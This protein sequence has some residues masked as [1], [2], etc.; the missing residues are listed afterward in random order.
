[1]NGYERIMCAINRNKPDMVP[2]FEIV[3]DHIRKQICPSGTIFDMY[4]LLDIDAIWVCE[5]QDDWQ[6]YLPKIKRDHFG[7]LRDFRLS[8]GVTFPFPYEPL[9]HT[10]EDLKCFLDQYQLPDPS[11]DVRFA[12]LREMVKRFKYRKAIVFAVWSS[13]LFPSFVRGFENLLIDYYDNAE[14]VL[15]LASRFSK[16]YAKQI[17]VA[18][19]LGAD[20]IMESEDFCGKNGPFMSLDHFNKFCMPG[21]KI[22]RDQARECNLP[23]IKHSDGYVWPFMD[24]FVNDLKIDA[25]HPSEPIA[26][27]RIEQV[28]EIYGDKIAVIGN[29]DCSHLLPYGT[30]EEITLA[31]KKCIENTAKDGG[32]ILSSSNC[33]HVAV[34]KNSLDAMISAARKYGKY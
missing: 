17:E 23:F 11:A 26:G 3:G 21:L 29:I 12:T 4:E 8:E 6:E 30:K 34:S 10:E 24:T 1:M 2:I 13:F 9:I 20:I 5:D 16:Y 22:V 32:Y 28:K 31:V 19:E 25:F 33:I 27:M 7:V 18:C 14:F 15:E